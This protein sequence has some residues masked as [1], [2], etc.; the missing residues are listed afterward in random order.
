MEETMAPNY[1]FWKDAVVVH[2]KSVPCCSR[3]KSVREHVLV[4]FYH[5]S[6]RNNI[7]Y[8]RGGFPHIL[9]G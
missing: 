3:L 1:Y 8:P 7:F 4:V 6:S 9:N 5:R 2:Q